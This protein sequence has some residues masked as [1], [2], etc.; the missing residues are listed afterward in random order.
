MTHGPTILYAGTYE[1]TY[2]RNQQ[3]IRLLRRAGCTVIE[4]HEPFWETMDD[5]SRSFR[6]PG[7]IAM[8]IVNLVRAYVRLFTRVAT[9]LKR[10]DGLMIGYIGQLDMLTIGLIGRLSRRPVIFNPLVTL[11]DTVVEDRS[12]ISK[13]SPLA[14]GIW[15]ID[16]LSTRIAS[17]VITDTA[18]NAAYICGM[19]GL[20]RSRIAVLHVGAD[21]EVFH[22]ACKVRT[23]RETIS[24]LFYGKMIPLHG[25]ET[26]LSAIDRLH[27]SA[28][29]RFRFEIVGSG[30]EQDRVIEFLVRNPDFAITYRHRVA[31]RRLA[32]R[33]ASSD[34]V[35]GIFGAG[36]KAGR[37]V[38]NKVFQAMAV[39]API[40]TRESPAIREVLDDESAFLIA[41]GDPDALCDALL[42]MEDSELR[43]RLGRNART[44][45]NR[46][47][48]D[49][50]LV[51]QVRDIL[52]SQGLTRRSECGMFL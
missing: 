26:I 32:Q 49:V 19:T 31:Y 9:N 39:G 23:D 16:W 17:L 3:M 51:E 29:S 37:V 27:Q 43:E 15:L 45:F 42:Q 21:E 35:L 25:I 22:D 52:A 33:I 36:D 44:A 47:G 13:A 28:P 34:V 10:C 7:T 18:E 20:S 14:R 5:K 11:T 2:P 1:R 8:A 46:Y 24:V 38:P 12:L 6:E 30:Q 40:I 48:S 41:A 50:A 4:I